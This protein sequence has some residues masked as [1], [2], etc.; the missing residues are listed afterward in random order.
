MQ[1]VY[2]QR[3][4]YIGLPSKIFKEEPIHIKNSLDF[5]DL[6]LNAITYNIDHGIN[7]LCLDTSEFS[8]LN[9]LKDFEFDEENPK[10]SKTIEKIHGILKKNDFRVC[11]L[12]PK[13][14]FLASQLEGVGEETSLYLERIS[15]I[16]DLLG[17]RGRSIIVRIGSAYGNRKSTLVTFNERLLELTESCLKKIIVVNDEKPSLFSVTDLISGCYYISGIP[18]CFRFLNH[19]F[20]DGG[21]N[22]REAFFLSCSTWKFGSNPI[23]IHAEPSEV[24]DSGIPTSPKPASFI[25]R[26]IPTFGLFPDVLIDSAEK[27]L[28]CIKYMSEKN[29]LKPIVINKKNDK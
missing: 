5:L 16:L 4:G 7:F 29:K 20:N 19:F 24:D 22:V 3:Y 1:E 13:D 23:I 28:A 8:D 6:I 27:E 9:F 21:L 2:Y 15:M 11:F 10:V 18:V 25:E 17:Q 26:R 14:Y 12:I